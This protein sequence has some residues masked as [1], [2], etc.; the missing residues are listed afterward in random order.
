MY[1][2]CGEDEEHDPGVE[3]EEYLA[4]AVC[5]DNGKLSYSLVLDVCAWQG[6]APLF[7]VSGLT[8]C[9]AA[10]RQCARDAGVLGFE[11]GKFYLTSTFFP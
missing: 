10:H 3:F 4:C 2:F 5:G 11:D 1:R 9:P 7:K 6:L 8:S